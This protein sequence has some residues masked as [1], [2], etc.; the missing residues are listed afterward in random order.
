MRPAPDTAAVRRAARKDGLV[1][2][3]AD[4]S[5]LVCGIV[6]VTPDSFFDGGRYQE[7]AQAVEH[8][9]ALV[10]EGA[11]L[12][13]IGGEST[14]PGSEPPTVD[15]EIA[16]V[17]PVID[18]LSRRTSVPMSVDTSRPEVMREAVAAGAVM[19]NDVRALRMPGALHT[20]AAL[21]VPVCLM[22]MQGEPRTM[23]AAP[24]YF[25]VVAQVRGFLRARIRA[26]RGAGITDSHIVLDPG[27]GFGKSVAHNLTLLSALGHISD[28]GF[29]VVA[30]LSRKSALGAVT[31]R[32][33]GDRLAA[34]IAAAVMATQR[35][36]S[37]LRVH[38]VA[39][40]VDA[41]AIMSAVA[42]AP[43]GDPDTAR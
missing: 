28:L 41:L 34:S 10:D 1:L 29:P 35:G 8:A 43:L 12:L 16:R 25:D 3:L 11:E 22:H 14:H 40:T 42:T 13:D 37:L 19:I 15:E 6:N 39:A 5:V 9:L 23:Q 4:P 24:T 20:A 32:G 2:R 36:A 33:P 38:D 27:F 31:G 21:Q 17:V 7:P 18:T 30:G 26:C